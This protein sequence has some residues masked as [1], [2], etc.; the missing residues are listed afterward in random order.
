MT[1]NEKRKP[2]DPRELERLLE[3]PET[4]QDGLDPEVEQLVDSLNRWQFDAELQPRA[5]F[6]HGLAHEL[7][8]DNRTAASQET[9]RKPLGIV[10]RMLAAGAAVAVLVLLLVY[11]GGLFSPAEPEPAAFEQTPVG[12]PYTFYLFNPF[13]ATELLVPL[14]PQTLDDRLNGE[15]LEPG[16]FFSADGSTRVD[17]EFPEGRNANSPNLNPEEIWIVVSDVQSGAERSRFHPPV[18]ALV[19]ALSKDGSRLVL[20]PY[21]YPTSPTAILVTWAATRGLVLEPYPYTTWPWPPAAEWYVLDT[22]DGQLLAHVKDVDNACF[23]QSAHFDP[24]LRRI[25]CVVDPMITEANEPEPM[26]IA[27]YDVESG[28]K[29]SERQLPDVLIGQRETERSDQ[30]VTELVEP[31]VVLSPDGQR[32]AI[33]HAD[34]DEVTL[35]DTR[36]LGIERTFS[37]ERSSPLWPPLAPNVAHA[38]GEITGTIRQAEFSLDGQHLYLYNVAQEGDQ[39]GLWLVNLGRGLIAAEALTGYQIQWVRPAPDGTV[40]VFGTTDE[41]LGPYEIR[42]SS[43]SMLWRLDART[44]E[45]LAERAFTG[46]RGGRLVLDQPTK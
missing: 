15:A 38:K 20:E 14:D 5:A 25:Y 11:A 16:G 45:I 7:Q 44:L 28:T 2:I 46:Y 29:A 9:K 23:R 43:P 27:A 37:W 39:H 30:T 33:V 36:T 26:R 1:N 41:S 34:A 40:Y 35:L 3:R 10:F 21:P 32:L 31:A 24:A 42:P 19:A 6:V 12:Q 18:E 4:Y 13:A 8:G 22:A 17:V